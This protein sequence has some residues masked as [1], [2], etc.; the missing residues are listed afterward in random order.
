MRKSVIGI[1][2]VSSMPSAGVES[3]GYNP[4]KKIAA[5]F[6][7]LQ[8]AKRLESM[9]I[10]KP[11]LDFDPK[12]YEV[13][14]WCPVYEIGKTSAG[15]TVYFCSIVDSISLLHEYVV[16]L[17]KLYEA[18]PND[19]FELNIDSPGGYIATATQICAAIR[20]CKGTVMTHASGMCASAGSLLWSVGHEVSIGDT[21]L[22]MWHMSS[23][24]DYG[25]SLAV[26]DEADFQVN[27][28]RDVLLDISLKRGF[29]TDDEIAKICTNPDEAIWI[30]A[31]EMRNRI[32]SKLQDQI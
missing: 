8:N 24:Y 21:A 13:N 11:K 3:Y 23:H 1:Q 18:G 22:F 14:E 2:G 12:L 20:E 6:A 16:L 32:E 10:S 27:Y 28:V 31:A 30:S 7:N 29:I 4:S 26:R 19:V 17:N 9:D 15:G 25:N 5:G